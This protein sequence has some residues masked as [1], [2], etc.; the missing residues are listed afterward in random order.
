MAPSGENVTAWTLFLCFFKV[1]RC[2]RVATS[3]RTT[4]LSPAPAASMVPSGENAT[5]VTFP[6]CP[7]ASSR[8]CLATSQRITVSSP[9][10]SM[11]PSGEN[12]TAWTP[13]P[14]PCRV[15]SCR[16]VEEPATSKSSV[17]DWP[18][19]V[20][21]DREES[22]QSRTVPSADA[23][24]ALSGENATDLTGAV[25]S[26]RVA[27]LLRVATSQRITVRPYEPDASSAPL[28]ENA[29]E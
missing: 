14:L 12:A 9:D 15:A 3:Q 1:S 4:V 28:G 5:E 23:S 8:F 16:H 7:R 27:R 29:T 25:C 11:V 22:C 6:R 20:G 24:S 19:P 13:D 17:A 18:I 21:S 2:F 10:A 26:L